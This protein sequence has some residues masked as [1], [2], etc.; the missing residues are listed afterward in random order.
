MTRVRCA[1]RARVIIA[2]CAVAAPALLRAQQGIPERT[3]TAARWT[4]ELVS[5]RADDGILNGGV[6]FTPPPSVAKRL[7]VVWIHGN[8]VNFYAPTYV[9]IGRALAARGFTTIIGNTRMHDLGN[10]AGYRGNT[11]IRGGS[12]WGLNS[13]QDRDLAAWI[14]LARQR[15]F[16][17]VVLVGHSAGVTAVQHY[18]AKTQDP[19]V[20]GLGLASGR[21]R[22]ADTPRDSARVAQARQMV[23]D[24]RGEEMPPS[25][26]PSRP[27]YTSAGTLLDLADM[28]TYLTDFFGVQTPDPPVTRIR[29][30]I[31]AWF[32]TNEADVGTAADLAL[33][34]ATLGRLPTGPSHVNTAMIQ[35]AD[36]MYGGQE[37]QVADTIA[38]W[39]D[40][41]VLPSA[42]KASSRRPE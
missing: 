21:F 30:P 1:S 8:G 35:N 39:I 4:E 29:C 13:E 7:A 33:L 19:R 26:N 42:A 38:R 22:P 40:G 10:I 12:Y 27:S 9:N 24:G 18:Q 25:V 2:A 36:H 16:D 23:A 3:A 11:R 14:E 31:L 37:A 17:R 6:V 41:V 32:G 20:I 28:G 5:A 15:G 34:T